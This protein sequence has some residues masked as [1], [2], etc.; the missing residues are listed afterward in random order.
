MT[1][2]IEFSLYGK[3]AEILNDWLNTDKNCMDIIHAGAGKSHLAA[4][5]LPL[6]A[7]N[8]R[9]HKGKDVV[10]ITGSTDMIKTNIWNTLKDT[11]INTYGVNPKDINNQDFIIKIGKTHIRCKSAEIRERIRGMNAGIILCD[12]AS[13]F[14]EEVLQELTNRLRPRVGSTD[15]PG[16]MIIISTPKGAGPLYTMYQQAVA[17]PEH[18]IVRHYNYLQM[19]S[20]N[21]EF[22]ENQKKILSPMKFASD[23]LVSFDSVEDQFY[24]SWDT[25]KYTKDIVDDNRPELYSFHDF[26]KKRM[27]AIVAR[28]NNPYSD[29]GTIEILKSYA[30]ADCSTEGIAQAIRADFPKRRI[31]SIIDMSGTQ[32]N[33]DTTSAFGVTDRT[34]LEKYGFSIINTTKGNPLITDTDNSANAF[35]SQGRLSVDKNDLLLQE[36]LQSYHYEDG[37][38]KKLVK[39]SEAKFMH[40]D[41]LGDALRYG[42]HHLFQ[43]QHVDMSTK[44]H[45]RGNKLPNVGIDHMPTSPLFPGGPTWEELENDDTDTG[46]RGWN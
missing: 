28:V 2:K 38:R 33:R 26:N 12:E 9:Y 43:L 1:Q 24:Y 34:L 44:A 19:R 37:T 16:R 15:S 27:A 25:I 13:L 46:Y 42:I 17:D 3:Q 7:S 30:I 18:W 36:A 41:G 23:Y 20:G 8:P 11:C 22:I 6:F 32:V 45:Y 21:L 40:I 10:F 31:N 5:A 39:Y 4:I 29:K 14:S 35:I